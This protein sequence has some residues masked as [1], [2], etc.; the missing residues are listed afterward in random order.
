MKLT[1]KN[2]N[3]LQEEF[4]RK[5]NLELHVVKIPQSQNVFLDVTSLRSD[6]R[7]CTDELWAL[8]IGQQ[9]R[10]LEAANTKQ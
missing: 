2:I 9:R 1:M 4:K 5:F 6:A 7:R 8:R 10:D 3:A